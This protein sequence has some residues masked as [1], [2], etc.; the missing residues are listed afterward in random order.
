M[1]RRILITGGNGFVGRNLAEALRQAGHE[2]LA[3]GR[4]ELDLRDERAV[5]ERLER[6]AVDTVI[7]AAGR[8]DGIAA[9]IAAPEAFFV[10]NMLIGLGV[11]RAA[12]AAGVPRLL[13]L[14]SS[15][16]YPKGRE[17]LAEEDLMTGPLEPTNEAYAIAKLAVGKLCEWVAHAN[18]ERIYRTILPCNL[19]GPHDKFHGDQAHLVAA[20]LAKVA[21][22]ERTGA[23][24]VVIWGDGTARREF[25]HVRDLCGAIEHLLPRLAELPPYLNVGVGHDHTINEY[26][27]V[28]A[29][30]VGWSGEFRHDLD[31]PVGMRRKLLDVTK[32]HALGWQASIALE[33]G[34]RDTYAWYLEH[35]REPELVGR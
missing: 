10:D 34:L 8:V 1:T 11:V 26:Y 27:A 6:D 30:A 33:D 25:M 35:G 15:C 31:R 23:G 16:V 22:A 29:R 12:D 14:S 28:A 13:N 20:I 19:Y 7:H 5:R 32:L 17:R 18:P 3:P 24:E 21:E 2:V 4:A 9:N